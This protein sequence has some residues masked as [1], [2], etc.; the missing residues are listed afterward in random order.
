MALYPGFGVSAYSIWL[1][2]ASTTAHEN[3]LRSLLHKHYSENVRKVTLWCIQTDVTKNV[4]DLSCTM[5]D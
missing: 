2:F 4:K 5:R 1:A 3:N